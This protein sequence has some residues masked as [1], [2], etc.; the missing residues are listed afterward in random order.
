[1][2]WPRSARISIYV[3]A[4]VAAR[5]NFCTLD[6]DGNVVDRRA[7]RIDDPQAMPLVERLDAIDL[8]RGIECSVRHVKQYRACV[9][10]RGDD[11]DGRIADTD[12]QRTGVPPLAPRAL[13]DAA[14]PTADLAARFIHAAHLAL[15]DQDVANGVLLRGFDGFRPLPSFA[16]LYGVRAAAVASYP[17]YLGAA[18]LAGMSAHRA[19]DSPDALAATVASV[20]DSDFVFLHYKSTDSR[21]E[22]GD[23]EGKIAEIEKADALLAR[24]RS[25]FDV[26][27]VTGD[28]STPA[29]MRSHSWHPVPLLI[30][31]DRARS[32]ERKF[33][34]RACAQGSLGK[35]GPSTY[36]RLCWRT[37]GAYGSSAPETCARAASRSS[38]VLMLCS[39]SRGSPNTRSSESR[40]STASTRSRRR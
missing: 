16:D 10:L 20:A 34:E 26:V 23:Y 27:M 37:P 13:A 21:G 11:L 19:P 29:R 15:A 40:I 2:C 18:R 7:G 9:I 25:A 39:M 12:P 6:G 5:I 28:H 3:R 35:C 30:H 1:M 36:C 38:G 17:M 32:N 14:G 4:I 22:D 24:L 8:G 33:G 31:S